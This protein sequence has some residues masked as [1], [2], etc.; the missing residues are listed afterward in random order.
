VKK[1]IAV[2]GTGYVGLVTGACMAE[3]GHNVVCVDN[4]KNKIRTLLKGQIPIYEP[5]LDEVVRKN[6]KAKRLRFVDNIEA[7]LEKAEGVFIAVN[8]PPLPNGE[9]DLSYVETVARQVAQNMR[10]YTIVIEKSTVPVETGE[11]IKQTMKLYGNSKGEF[12]VVS[13]PEFLREGSAVQDFLHPDRVVVG[14]ES[15]RAETFMRELYA[16]LKTNLIVTDIKSSELIKHSSNS[17]LAMKISF[18][19]SVAQMCERVGADVMRVAEGMGFDA[20][21]GR[22]FLNA[23][24]GYGGSC[25]PKD[26]KAYIHMAEKVGYNFELLKVVERV[27]E[28]QKLWVIEKLKKSLWNLRGKTIG[29]L[30]LAFKGNTDD[31][32]NA[33]SID[34]IEHLLQSGCSVRAYDP[35]AMEKARPLIGKVQLCK[36]AYDTVKGADAVV[37]VTEWPEF[38]EIDL[39]KVKSLVQTPVFLDGRNLF[40]PQ[41]VTD[42]GFE[43]HGV[44]RAAP[45]MLPH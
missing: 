26:I 30:G 21:I 41:T 10:R 23:G 37:V 40:N 24:L 3:I 22:S 28:T 38:K 2:I 5:G 31:M 7:G 29:L 17:F 8:T 36:N 18:I 4:D 14:V 16:P 9:A 15:K 33:P 1:D 34:I 19:N 13:N 45:R 43:Y 6:V 44:G 20:R 27:N 11:K 35:V 32:R 42:L 25:F 12:D 39:K